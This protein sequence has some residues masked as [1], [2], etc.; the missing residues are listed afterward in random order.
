M[1]NYSQADWE[2]CYQEI[3]TLV[4]RRPTSVEQDHLQAFTHHL[5]TWNQS[6]NL[7]GPAAVSTLIDRHI[8]DSLTLHPLFTPGAKIADMGSGAGFPALILAILSDRSQTFHL[9]ETSQKKARFLNFIVTELQLSHHVIIFNQQV[10]QSAQGGSYDFAT[11][12][13]LANLEQVAKLAKGLLR[14][15]G[16]SL[17]LKGKNVQDEIDSF[18]TSPTARHFTPPRLLATPGAGVIVQMHKVSRET[19]STP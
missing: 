8:L 12:R 6:F 3:H 14:P 11:S 7:V 16:T 19:G 2:H 15:G 13:A 10:R 9:Y 5:L 1:N 4:G 17:A 18:L